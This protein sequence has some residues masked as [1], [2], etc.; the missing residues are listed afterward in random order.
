[1]AQQGG[2]WRPS[3]VKQI[4]QLAKKGNHPESP[5]DQE[6]LTSLDTSSSQGAK[7]DA[8][9]WDIVKDF[10]AE[11]EAQGGGISSHF[12]FQVGWGKWKMSL[13]SWDVNV[14]IRREA[15]QTK[16]VDPSST[17]LTRNQNSDTQTA[18]RG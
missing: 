10:E 6:I 16:E 5:E 2:T 13:F 11:P 4:K 3:D 12:N 17:S 14:N 8:Q 9:E 7:A 18:K 15:I 1:M